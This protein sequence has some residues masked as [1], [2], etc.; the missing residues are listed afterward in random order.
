MPAYM[1]SDATV[2]DQAL[3]DDYAQKARPTVIAHGGKVHAA[4]TSIAHKEG[5]WKPKR[6]VIIEFPSM[7]AAKGWYDSAEYQAILP[8]RLKA[9]S[10]NLLFVDG[11]S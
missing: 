9:S 2:H 6:L 3:M 10:G 1:I 5:A 11:L 8:M 4:G 7:A